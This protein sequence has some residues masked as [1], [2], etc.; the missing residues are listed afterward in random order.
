MKKKVALVAAVMALMLVTLTGCGGG[1]KSDSS[2]AD[3]GDKTELRFWGWWSSEARKPYL[4]EMVKDYNESQDKYHV[5]YED[6]PFG[7]IFTKNIAQIAAG[8]PCDIIANTMEEVNFR[9]TEDQTVAMDKYLKDEDT[10]AFYDQYINACKA[11][12]G[13][14]YGLPLSVDTRAI[15]YNK[16]QF[17]EAGIKAEDIKTWDDL[18]EAARKL[19]KKD[20]KKWSRVGFMPL[21]GNGDI[22]TWI[23]NANAGQGYYDEDLKA[24]VNSDVNKD[25]MKWVR[26]QI[27]YYGQS[28]YDELKAAFDSGM[29]DP[30][31]SGTMSMLVNTSAYTAVLKQNAPDFDYGVIQIPEYKEG[32]GHVANGGGFVLEIPKGA[33]NPEGS[34]DFIKYVTSRETQEFLSEKLGDFSA[35]NDIPEDS[36]FFKDPINQDLEKCLQDT[37][38]LSLPNKYKGFKDVLTPLLDE[39]TLGKKS[40]D[41]SLDNAQKA[42]ENFKANTDSN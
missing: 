11:D 22:D 18:V 6:I 4:E 36:K 12:D 17:E 9:A 42:L 20:G 41:A 10:K 39:G 34:A 2:K 24:T 29:T 3:S 16:Q 40:V 28:E 35:R 30:F 14:T 38:T 5:T 31:A 15:Y 26:D 7:D 19:D 25:V 23:T 37:Y 21:L 1:S 27:E 13:K 32:N 33:K 8:N